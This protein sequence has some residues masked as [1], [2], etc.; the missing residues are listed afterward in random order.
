MTPADLTT[1]AS[2]VQRLALSFEPTGDHGQLLDA[3]AHAAVES[4]PG[5]D[6][7][8]L[9]MPAERDD[10][11]AGSAVDASTDEARTLQR[12][13]AGGGPTPCPTSPSAPRPRG[14]VASVPPVD[15]AATLAALGVTAHLAVPLESRRGVVAVLDLLS[16]TE[17]SLAPSEPIAGLFGSLAAVVVTSVSAA[18]DLQLAMATREVVGQ[19]SGLVMQRDGVDAEEAVTRL[20]TLS[21]ATNVKLRVVAQE[22]VQRHG[23][24][25][26]T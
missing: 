3:I 21:Q 11:S 16:C 24:S 2:V 9:S 8:V 13:L 18:H 25:T 7:A 1:M 17:D 12:V 20:V 19:A 26:T 5:V 15:H 14:R 10:L 23:Q 22:L 6:H 4:I